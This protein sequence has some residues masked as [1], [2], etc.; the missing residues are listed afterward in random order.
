MTNLAVAERVV[1]SNRSGF[2]LGPLDLIAGPGE[3]VVLVG[4]N[5]AGKSTLLRILAGIWSPHRGRVEWPLLD[6]DSSKSL[7]T[8][9]GY[10]QQN[11]PGG[12][13]S[14]LLGSSASSSGGPGSGGSDSDNLAMRVA[15]LVTLG[16]YVHRRADTPTTVT[17]A[18]D[19]ALA[20][21]GLSGFHKRAVDSL[22]GGE[23]KRVLVAAVLAQQAPLLV[24]DE[25][26]AHLDPASHRLMA[27]AIRRYVQTEAQE[28]G[29]VIATHDL[30]FARTI[31]TRVVGLRQGAMVDL[32]PPETGFS[33]ASLNGLFNTDFVHAS[34]GPPVV[35]LDASTQQEPGS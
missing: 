25:P 21:V 3:V 10:L 11:V 34:H 5:G 1:W 16:R 24:L 2:Q 14:G 12:I 32:G 30:H 15:E 35:E 17:A 27:T 23:R 6:N 22:S 28:R 31:A 18:V 9:V 8:V 26:T 7:A 33:I 4:E 13:G 19:A 29:A 20:A